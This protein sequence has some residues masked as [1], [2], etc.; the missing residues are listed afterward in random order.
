MLCA[1]LAVCLLP[2]DFAFVGICF[3][4]VS[5]HLVE[6][7]SFS[8]LVPADVTGD[9]TAQLH[10]GDLEVSLR[11]PGLSGKLLIGCHHA[12]LHQADDSHDPLFFSSSGERLFFRHAENKLPVD[13]SLEKYTKQLR[14]EGLVP[15]VRGLP[16]CTPR[17]PTNTS[18]REMAYDMI[19]FFDAHGSTVPSAPEVA[20]RCA[21]SGHELMQ[22]RARTG[23][24]FL[25]LLHINATVP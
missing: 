19:S 10:K 16:W 21:D 23:C 1:S 7:L 13:V 6:L 15:G 18:D 4:S 24:R 11:F 14:N 22:R 3:Q 12:R 25:C 17:R 9:V 20:E 5:E 8:H 2:V